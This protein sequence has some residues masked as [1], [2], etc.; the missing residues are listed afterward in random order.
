MLSMR[1]QVLAHG[2]EPIRCDPSGCCLWVSRTSIAAA[3]RRLY[4]AS[5]GSLPSPARVES[6]CHTARCVNLDHLRVRER[7]RASQ[8]SATKQECR[9]G[10]ELSPQNVV[11]H[12]DGRIAYCRL[13]R[14]ER[15][16]ERYRTDRTFA[17]REIARQRQLRTRSPRRD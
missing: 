16:R 17:E 9:R 5:R 1:L 14:N 8:G 13:C 2:S 12:R 10:H 7:S 11:R 6:V 3:R 4:E 15:R